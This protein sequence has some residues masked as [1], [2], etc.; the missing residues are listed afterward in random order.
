MYSFVFGLF[1]LAL[2]FFYGM[3]HTFF[4]AKKLKHQ[5]ENKRKYMKYGS[6]LGLYGCLSVMLAIIVYYYGVG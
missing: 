1:S 5:L 3:L 4:F 2:L 6:M